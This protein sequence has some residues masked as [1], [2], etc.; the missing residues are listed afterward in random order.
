M[1]RAGLVSTEAGHEGG[2]ARRSRELAIP[3][4]TFAASFVVFSLGFGDWRFGLG[5]VL[6]LLVH[7]LGH[8]FEARRQGLHVTLPRF[9]PGFG[10]YVRH[11]LNPT[12]WRNALISLAGPLVGGLGAAVLWAVGSAH[13]SYLLLE[14]AYLGFLINAAN[15]FPVGF[16]DG[17]AAWRSIGETWRRPRIRYEDGVPVEASAPERNRAVQIVILYVV[18][19]VVL[20]GC[21]LATRNPG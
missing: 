21:V 19:A 1:D 13:D 4:V 5:V 15:L 12:P 11:E 2:L 20:V 9:I 3:I 16:L 14:L 18:L 7:E 17:G 10:A 8:L 6:L